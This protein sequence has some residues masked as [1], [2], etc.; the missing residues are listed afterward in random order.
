MN[1][2]RL[3]H[4]LFLGLLAVAGCVPSPAGSDDALG[5]R[6]IEP[7]AQI[8][9]E[10]GLQI[11][12]A[13]DTRTRNVFDEIFERDTSD[14]WRVTVDGEEI[15][16]YIF[17]AIP[18]TQQAAEAISPDAQTFTGPNT[19]IEIDFALDTPPRYWQHENYII[20]YS[21]N[22]WATLDLLDSAFGE[23]IGEA[24]GGELDPALLKDAQ[25]YADDYGIDLEEVMI[26]LNTQE[27]IGALNARLVSE[28]RETFAGLWLEH[29]PSYRLVV[30][31][32]R[33]G[34]ATLA[35]Y[36][37][38]SSLEDIVEV[39]TADVTHEELRAIQSETSRLLEPLSMPVASGINIQENLVEL[40]VTDLAAFDAG[41]QAHNIQLPQH[42]NIVTIYEPLGDDLPFEVVPDDSIYFPQLKSRSTSFME[43]L[44][45]GRL[46]VENGCLQAFQEESNQSYTIVWQTDYF[47]H[48]NDG[49][50]E[51][52][53]R[54]GKV[55]AWVGEM[56]YLGG[57]HVGSIKSDQL[58]APIPER[59]SGLPLWL[60]G[61]FVP[62]EYIPNITGESQ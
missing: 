22:V 4:V 8:L 55:V 26:R 43:A 6:D 7:L 47:L 59:C 32:T 31:F 30:A 62:D 3:I 60:M 24:A 56:I 20:Y 53:D 61:E 9:E 41:I 57:G 13:H 52:L 17:D 25:T 49:S 37:Q 46:V 54:D 1:K 33:D 5:E 39:R 44:L 28:E 23:R 38:G 45:I 35:P 27:A 51:M 21:G 58:Q 14:V 18:D 34:E 36:I 12:A 40:Y 42:L 50:I 29:Q 10:R 48:N 15:R 11:T 19:V 2:R 16:V